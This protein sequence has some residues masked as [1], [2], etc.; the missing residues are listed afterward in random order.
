MHRQSTL[1]KWRARIAECAELGFTPREYCEACEL[2]LALFLRWC[3]WLSE[4]AA[5]PA[6]S[7]DRHGEAAVATISGMQATGHGTRGR[8]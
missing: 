2:S 8:A 5:V 1:E 6:R 4:A 3:R 7:A